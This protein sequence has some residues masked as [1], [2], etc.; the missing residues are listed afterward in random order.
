MKR[1]QNSAK[2]HYFG[3]PL[4]TC[5]SPQSLATARQEANEAKADAEQARRAASELR[6]ALKAAEKAA[7]RHQES[8]AVQQLGGEW[9]AGLASHRCARHLFV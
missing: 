3:A 7:Q 4:P 2:T 6:E 1:Q 9:V 5:S 8:V